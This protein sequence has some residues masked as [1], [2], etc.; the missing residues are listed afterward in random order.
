MSHGHVLVNG[1]APDV[2]SAR[3]RLHEVVALCP[4]AHG[5]VAH[6]RAAGGQP[7]PPDWL[8]VDTA[9]VS[10]RVVSL[11]EPSSIP[12]ERDLRLVIEFYA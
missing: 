9:Q 5:I 8:A 2:P 11:P 6:Q 3:V 7:T 12:F 4:V 10:V 1:R